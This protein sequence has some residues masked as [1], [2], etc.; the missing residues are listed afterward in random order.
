MKAY[1]DDKDRIRL[2]RPELNMNRLR[3]SCHRIGLPVN[4]YLIHLIKLKICYIK[5]IKYL[6]IQDFD[7]NEF[8]ECLKMLLKID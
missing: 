5:Y 7:G 1:K 4:L 8:L 6:I 2:F 3:N